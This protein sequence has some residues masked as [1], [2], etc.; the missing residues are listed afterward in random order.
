MAWREILWASG[1]WH[2]TMQFVQGLENVRAVSRRSARATALCFVRSR[3]GEITTAGSRFD[4]GPR[5]IFLRKSVAQLHRSSPAL[6]VEFD[7]RLGVV[8][9]KGDLF[10]FHVEGVKPQICVVSEMRLDGR[11]DGGVRARVR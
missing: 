1:T 8:S 6:R 10:Q 9:V 7:L 11:L 4:H 2:A 5:A 3:V